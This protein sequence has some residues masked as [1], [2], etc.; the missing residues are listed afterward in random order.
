M[1]AP[2]VAQGPWTEIT[3]PDSIEAVRDEIGF[4]NPNLHRR[5]SDVIPEGIECSVAVYGFNSYRYTSI[6]T[7]DEESTTSEIP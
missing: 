1:V 2:K 3:D 5:K 7:H 4:T 6:V